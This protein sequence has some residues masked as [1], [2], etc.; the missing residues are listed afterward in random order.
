MH[1]IITPDRNTK[2]S[3]YTGAFR[4]EALTYKKKI[5]VFGVLCPVEIVTFDASASMSKR[6]NTVLNAI[7]AV[8]NEGKDLID[9][10]AIFSHGWS[11]GIQAGFTNKDVGEL[12]KLLADCG[13]SNDCKVALYCCS[14]GADPQDDS[15][16]APG[17]GSSEDGNLGDGSFAD[18]LRDA[19]C[20]E[21]HI[22][23]SV[24]A[25]RTAGHTTQNPNV[26]IFEGKGLKSG[27]YG[28]VMPIT[29]KNKQAWAAWVKKLKTPY[30]FTVPLMS[31]LDIRDQFD[32]LGQV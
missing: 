30:R 23:C 21:G 7:A 8:G 15:M 29:K 27:G 32:S 5:G 22:Y 26:I 31:V 25:H 18:R 24:Y 13:H 17:V 10:L 20:S 14:T 19:L 2:K 6:K 9:C 16:E 28:G 1:L 12:A 3:D 4:P 11:K